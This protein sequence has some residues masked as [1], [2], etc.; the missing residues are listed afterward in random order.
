VSAAS[1][2]R[3]EKASV[4]SAI[5]T[6]EAT[7]EVVKTRRTVRQ[8]AH[9]ESAPEQE[10]TARRARRADLLSNNGD[11][12]GALPPEFRADQPGAE[13]RKAGAVHDALAQLADRADLRDKNGRYLPGN[14]GRLHSLEYSGQLKAALEPLK[15]DIVQRVRVQLGV[16]A[17][18]GVETLN[19]VIDMY[20]EARLLRS[21]A[22]VRLAQLGGFIT[23][24]GR[25]RAL[26]AVWGQA[27]DREM[28]AAE[29][30]GLSRRAQRTQSPVEWLQSLDDNN[31]DN[32]RSTDEKPDSTSGLV[33]EQEE[34]AD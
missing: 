22:F 20:A 26:L 2:A 10:S 27:F 13:T 8:T 11:S 32:E 34:Q 5:C 17:G 28:R 6:G 14:T 21:S 31:S 33:G 9:S 4:K 3:D 23:N 25:S 1:D 30:L 7:G 15:R 18:D 29:K 12:A 19:G 16:D 24:K